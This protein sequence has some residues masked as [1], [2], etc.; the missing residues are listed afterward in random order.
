MQHAGFHHA[1][2]LNE[3]L[4]STIDTPGTEMMAMLQ[5]L[6]I[7]DNNPPLEDM[8]PPTDPPAPTVNTVAHTEVQ[9]EMLHSL[10]QIQ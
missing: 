8:P 4:H 7:V 5:E 10:H 3:Q 1:N 6:V 2:M 9:M